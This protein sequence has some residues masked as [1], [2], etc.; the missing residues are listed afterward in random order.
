MQHKGTDS[1]HPNTGKAGKE[2]EQ[3]LQ[4][5]RGQQRLVTRD[6]RCRVR[7]GDDGRGT[8]CSSGRLR[9]QEAS[10]VS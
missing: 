1:Q 5:H 7:M 2:R 3:P 8:E 4:R 6:G 10:S 9:S